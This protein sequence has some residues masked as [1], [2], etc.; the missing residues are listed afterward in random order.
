MKLVPNCITLSRIGLALLLLYLAPLGTGFTVV[1]LLCGITDLLDG[2]IARMSGTVS[3]LGAKLDSVADMT[4]AGTALYTLYPFLGLTFGLLLWIVLIA[5]IR[6][7]SILTAL[8]KFSTYG[9]IHTYGNKLAGLLLFLTPLLLPYVNQAIWTIAVCLIA[10]LSA[11]EELILLLIS[12]EL[13]LDRKGL[14]V[15]R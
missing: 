8:R 11:I 7:A 4:L 9:S 1:Y 14:Y 6:G 2:P 12:S 13:Q 5:V 3:S 10:T 15:R